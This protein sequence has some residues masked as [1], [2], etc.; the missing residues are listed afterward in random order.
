MGAAHSQIC[1]REATESFFVMP[2]AR[3]IERFALFVYKVLEQRE[4]ETL[5]Y[6]FLPSC[7]ESVLKQ[8][9]WMAQGPSWSRSWMGRRRKGSCPKERKEAKCIAQEGTK[10]T[11]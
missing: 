6:S 4:N 8:S 7:F 10:G 9:F 3:I 5:T 1:I 11:L 2:I